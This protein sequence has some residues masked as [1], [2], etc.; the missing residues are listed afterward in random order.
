MQDGRGAE[1]SGTARSMARAPAGAHHDPLLAS[2]HHLR[3]V[4]RAPAPPPLRHICSYSHVKPQ[5]VAGRRHISDLRVAVRP[6]TD[7]AP[8]QPT[9]DT[10]REEA[11]MRGG[12]AHSSSTVPSLTF[13]NSSSLPSLGNTRIPPSAL[14]SR[15]SLLPPPGAAAAA[16]AAELNGTA[17]GK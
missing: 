2:R 11:V 6:A 8:Q 4:Q 1:Q 16:A 3:C 10:A 17:R 7:R 9:A 12:V 13:Q 15:R 14:A 5:S